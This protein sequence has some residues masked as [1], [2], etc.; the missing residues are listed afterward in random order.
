LGRSVST[1]I[2]AQ[3]LGDL[4]KLYVVARK[5]ELD[6]HVAHIPDSF[7]AESKE[8][9]DRDYMRELFRLGY[10]LGTSGRAWETAINGGQ[11]HT[12][13]ASKTVANP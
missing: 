5:Y 6:Y 8:A 1:L 10:D 2:K 4:A 9:F 7:T 12:D 13:T 3:G 11:D